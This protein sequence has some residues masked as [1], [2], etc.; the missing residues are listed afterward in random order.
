MIRIACLLVFLTAT[1]LA[2]PPSR[3]LVADTDPELVRAIETALAPWKIAIIVDPASTE[4]R[5]LASA[6]AVDAQ[7]IVWRAGA[8]LVVFDRTVGTSQRRASRAGAL[9]PL[10]AAA[11]ALT[12]KTMLRLPPLVDT[13]SPTALTTTSVGSATGPASDRGPEL[14]VQVGGGARL[15]RSGQAELGGRAV[16]AMLVRPSGSLGL[17]IGVAGD[18]GTSSSVSQAGFKGT[19]SDWAVLAIASWSW[20]IGPLEVAP[21]VGGGVSRS[22]LDGEIG[23][24]AREES[25]VLPLLR[26]GVSVRWPLGRWSIGLSLDADI[27]TGAPTYMKDQ[28]M[29]MP[30]PLFEVPG[31]AA[32]LSAFAAADLGR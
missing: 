26:A 23:Q 32:T 17:R 14:R 31:F 4:E 25:E 29:G 11:A 22:H 3:V 10:S 30:S 20:P 21:A 15:A 28:G 27:V 6:K 5:A 2:A 16:L 9:D 8:E 7:F 24:V 18:L 13:T 1:S 12:V 19:W